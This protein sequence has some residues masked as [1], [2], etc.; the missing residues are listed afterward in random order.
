VARRRTRTGHKASQ[1]AKVIAGDCSNKKEAGHTRLKA[2]VEH[3]EVTAPLYLPSQGRV[4]ESKPA[5][6]GAVPGGDKK[7]VDQSRGGIAQGQP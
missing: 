2:Q 3:W 4:D 7:V 6:I 1:R 5:E